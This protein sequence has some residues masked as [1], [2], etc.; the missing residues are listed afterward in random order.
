MEEAIAGY[1]QSLKRH[2]DPIP[3]PADE[4]VIDINV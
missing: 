2:G 1:L 4:D 3:P